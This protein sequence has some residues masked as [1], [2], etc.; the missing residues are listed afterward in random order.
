MLDFINRLSNLFVKPLLRSPLHPLVSKH[1]MLMTFT[2]RK[3]GKTYSTPVQYYPQSDGSVIFFTQKTR[4]W[5]KNLRDRDFTLRIA[6]TSFAG[7]ADIVESAS[8]VLL[9][10][11]RAYPKISDETAI[12]LASEAVM[13][14]VQ[15]LRITSSND[16]KVAKSPG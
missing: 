7:K 1:Y 10:F 11:K 6:G 9:N 14:R 4:V 2:G 8:D 13:V 12:R 15:P 16:N 3:S 5:W